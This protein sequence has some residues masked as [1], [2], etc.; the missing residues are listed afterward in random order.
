MRCLPFLVLSAALCASAAQAQQVNRCTDAQGRTVYGDRSCAAMGARAR[1]LPEAR[2]AG[3]GGL[4]RDTCARRLSEVVAQIRSA[5]DARDANR[6][7]GIYFWNGLS[8]AA[9]TRVMDRLDAI[10]QRPLVDIAP[11]FP[12]DPA[13]EPVETED[14]GTGAGVGPI[15]ISNVPV[16][17]PR[18]VALRLEQ[19][20]GRSATPSRTLLKLRRQYNCFWISL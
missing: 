6:L 15:M 9:A 1:L 13:L 18:P 5:A 3:T 14:A 8:S 7:S 12:D 2:A 10:V 11:V 16:L 19:T 20:L 4:Y 17:R